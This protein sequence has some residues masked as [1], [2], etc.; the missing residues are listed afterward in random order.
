LSF[1]GKRTKSY[2]KNWAPNGL[3]STIMDRMSI[4]ALPGRDIENLQTFN[5]YD[6]EDRIEYTYLEKA[7]LDITKI[8]LT[9][10]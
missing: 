2:G 5:V 8:T 1:S 3:S 10:G 7:D 4:S 9:E 6:L